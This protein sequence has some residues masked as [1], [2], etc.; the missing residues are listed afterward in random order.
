MKKLN[1]P[2]V[3]GLLLAVLALLILCLG[4][5]F[6]P[7][8][9]VREPVV[10]LERDAALVL[11]PAA[12]GESTRY[13][14]YYPGSKIPQAIRIEAKSG[15]TAIVSVDE[16]GRNSRATFYFPEAANT[17]SGKILSGGLAGRKISRVVEF[18]RDGVSIALD[19]S[20]RKDGSVSEV[21]VRSELGDLV[22][23]HMRDRSS[24]VE[25]IKIYEP[26]DGVLTGEK[27]FNEKG[28][29]ATS[30]E[31]V[32]GP[33]SSTVRRDFFGPFGRERSVTYFDENQV[34][35]TEYGTDG[36]PTSAIEYQ[37]STATAVDFVKGVRAFTRSLRYD[38]AFLVTVCDGRGEEICKQVWVKFDPDKLPAEKRGVV[39]GN[40]YL[41]EV[42]EVGYGSGKRMTWNFRVGGQSV[43]KVTIQDDSGS[44]SRV[45]KYFSQEGKLEKTVT[46]PNYGGE[47]EGGNYGGSPGGF[48]GGN[49]GGFS[50]G[51]P[52]SSTETTP[53]ADEAKLLF[54]DRG[55]LQLKSDYLKLSPLTEVKSRE[56]AKLPPRGAK[57]N[58]R[59]FFD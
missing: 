12:W 28:L 16:R 30:M 36:L 51:Y 44:S 48:S 58:V 59:L 11:K 35:L 5:C 38:K 20:L 13:V 2:F 9:S 55:E 15:V 10:F 50:G 32:G 49:S 24:A 42:E 46:H 40:Y 14:R 8:G 6:W 27:V 52:G 22:V 17:T 31:R 1:R 33:G 57:R 26:K 25:S 29:L 37:Y 41:A 45:E 4:L 53:T 23:T 19:K 39:N 47:Y 54:K 34:T 21:A 3:G 18:K 56:E 43:E 7:A